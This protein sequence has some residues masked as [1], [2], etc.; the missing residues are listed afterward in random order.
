MIEF[1]FP[2]GFWLGLA[3]VGVLAAHLVRRRARRVEVPFLPLWRQVESHQR[4]GFGSAASR[5]IDLI[6]VL[7]ACAAV[8]AAAARPFSPG[9][10]PTVRDLVVVLDG[11]IGLA[12]GDRAERLRKIAEAEVLRRARGTRIT[13]ISIGDDGE[14]VWTGEDFTVALARIA[15]HRPG[16]TQPSPETALALGREAAGELTDPDLVFCTFRP[17][18][19]FE[20]YRLRTIDEEIPNAGIVSIEVVGSTEGAGRIAR[21]GLRGEGEV[22][23]AGHWKGVVEGEREVDVALPDQG[24]VSLKVEFEGDRFPLDDVAYLVLPDLKLPRVLVV[25][26]GETSPFLV[27]ALSALEETGGIRGPLDQTEPAR[28]LEAARAYDVLIFDRCVPPNHPRELRALYLAP[29][30]AVSSLP[31]RTGEEADA[32]TLFDVARTHPLLQGFDLVRIPPR[33]A[34]PVFGGEVVASAAPGPV[35]AVGPTWVALGFDP[36]R[37]ILASSPA[38][39]LLL[40]NALGLLARAVHTDR[41]EFF[42]IGDEAPFEGVAEL[43]DGSHRR[44]AGVLEGPPGFWTVED[45]GTLGVNLLLP[46]LDLRSAREESDPLE[47]VGDP[48]TPDRPLTAPFSAGALVLLLLAWWVFWRR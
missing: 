44:L 4:S 40:R 43:P 13:V 17:G 36:D 8:A 11:G 12:A 37:C 42:A 39:P 27:A 18:D 23:I 34:R 31:F 41:P 7:V 6:M 26:E 33:R 24:E 9:E 15:E 46:E 22:S 45:E 21:L 16:W 20:G 2:A 30:G 3:A 32:P 19:K 10:L 38:Y 1:G 5:L 48:G 47:P 25:A 14:S 35:L 29:P 28:A